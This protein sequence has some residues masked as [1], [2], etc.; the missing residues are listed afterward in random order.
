MALADVLAKVDS[1]TDRYLELL[2]DYCRLPTISAQ[3]RA[4][5][6]TAAFV[7][8][9]L[10]EHGFEAREFPTDGG[11]NVV[12]AQLLVNERRPTLLMYEHYDVQPVDPVNEWR[13][14]PFDPVIEDGKFY[15]RGCGDTKGNFLA[16]LLAVRAWQEA[17]GAPPVN[18]KFVVEGE[19]EIGSRHFPSFVH[20]NKEILKADGA[21]IEGGDHLP[22]GR[23]KIELGCKGILYVDL[24]CR[25]AVVDQHSMY[26]AISP[27]PAWRLIHAL[28]TL[29]DERGR[30]KIPGWAEDA[31][32]PTARE[33]RYLRATALKPEHLKQFWGVHELRGGD[34]P[35]EV[36][37]TLVYSPTCTICGIWSGYVEEGTKTVNPAVAHVK[38]DFRLVPKMRIE[39]QLEKLRTHLSAKGFGDIE[40]IE[41]KE[42]LQPSAISM[43]ARVVKAAIRGAVD[44]Y[45]GEPEVW[46]WSAGASANGFFNDVVGVPSISGPG[47]SYD[48]SNYHAPNE[49]IRIADFVGG[50]KH[51]AAMMGRF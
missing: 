45:G 8:R 14:D 51:M 25:T 10:T 39:K 17:A 36:V 16:Q 37:K 12:Y 43:T 5:P 21:T 34:D 4:Q 47:V 50:A 1:D 11:P 49:N 38:L 9:V 23:P 42:T 32:R 27:N 24:V 28:N 31:R 15:A 22:D 3:K 6:E 41:H 33:L 44:A 20:A 48:G 19:E 46:P 13:R 26:A 40:I 2:K 7:R 18:L 29:R 30:I 35:F